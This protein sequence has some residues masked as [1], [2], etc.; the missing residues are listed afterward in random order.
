[1]WGGKLLDPTAY[2]YFDQLLFLLVHLEGRE[3]QSNSSTQR[4][5]EE[6][7]AKNLQEEEEKELLRNIR[8]K[9]ANHSFLRGDTTAD[10]AAEKYG[11]Y[12]LRRRQQ[13]FIVSTNN[14]QAV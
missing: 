7:E 13:L 1:M 14:L 6:K 10:F 9:E 4:N 2:L 12:R 3:T 8:K 5:E 11:R